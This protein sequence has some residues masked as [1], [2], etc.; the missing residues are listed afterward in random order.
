MTAP[1]RIAGHLRLFRL[2]A[3]S[4]AIALLSML[5]VGIG[6][7]CFFPPGASFPPRASEDWDSFNNAIV[8]ASSTA[9]A[10]A[11]ATAFAFAIAGKRKW[12]LEVVIAVI[13]AVAVLGVVVYTCFWRYPWL[14]RSRMGQWEFVRLR[15]T[16]L[17]W[18]ST[19]AR[20]QIPHSAVVG[21]V[22]G[23]VAGSLA[24]LSR[25]QPRIAMGMTL[26]LLFA[27]TLEP[28]QRVVFEI[29]VFW[30]YFV[31]WSIESPG[32]TVQFVPASGATFGAIAGALIAVAVLWRAQARP[33][34][35]DISHSRT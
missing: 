4:A 14:A 22:L 1:Q 29:V 2:A 25:R 19:I 24:I 23:A 20:Y 34:S 26:G 21:L 13:F 35:E 7:A 18:F 15:D 3:R 12:A 31:R 6:T 28:V 17:R 10:G 33:M 16:S 5:V 11:V 9:I 30:G 27:I 32:M 8:F